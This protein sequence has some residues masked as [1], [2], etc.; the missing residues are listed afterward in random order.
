MAG[1][2]SMP[3][4]DTMR[5][6]VD[7]TRAETMTVTMAV[8]ASVRDLKMAI[9]R[10]SGITTTRLRLIRQ[11]TSLTDGSTLASYGISDGMTVKLHVQLDVFVVIATGKTITLDVMDSDTINV[12]KAKIRDAEGIPRDQQRLMF[13]MEELEGWLTIAEYNIAH[14]AT[15]HL[16]LRLQIVVQT[17]TG[18]T[19][20]M[21]VD[22]S[23]T[24]G[25]VLHRVAAGPRG[26]PARVA[27]IMIL[28]RQ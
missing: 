13:A 5:I 2:D 18:E 26:F 24:I 8:A 20:T 6:M 23:D 17:P 16:A 1:A 27:Q 21:D 25:S 28:A 15:L 10:D 9:F 14:G 22:S 12:V 11:R 4:A 3:V 7:N 19:E